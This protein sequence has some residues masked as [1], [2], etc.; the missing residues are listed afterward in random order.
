[1]QDLPLALRWYLWTVY[2]ACLAL[3]A[4]QI[5]PLIAG[6]PPSFGL[7]R[8]A[9]F[10]L[11][12][13]YIGERTYLQVGASLSQSLST[14]VHLTVVLLLPPPYPVVITFL[15]VLM[16]H[17]ANVHKPLYKRAFNICH[18]TL[19][20]GL[21]SALA[22]LVATPR[23]LLQSDHFLQA[24]PIVV[25]YYALDAGLLVA[26]FALLERRSPWLVWRQA[27]RPLL[28]PEVA[29][30][31]T[32]V[33][34][35]V[36]WL[37]HPELLVLF[38]MPVVALRAA[39]RAISQAEAQAAALQRRSEQLEAVL[40]AGQRLRLQQDVAA[41]L[42]SAAAAAQTIVG[43]GAVAGYA[44]SEEE[45]N[46][47][48]RVALVP[49][50]SPIDAP[51]S[52]PR[53]VLGDIVDGLEG[54]QTVLL[55]LE[56]EGEGIVGVLRLM[57]VPTALSQGDRNAL[58]ILATETSIA[59]ENAR[60]FR[61][62]QEARHAAEEAVRVRDDFLAAASHDL[63]TPLTV[64]SGLVQVILARLASGRALDADQ[65]QAQIATVNEAT[66]RMRTTVEEI[67]DA[68]QLQMGQTL[69][70]HVT[71]LDLGELVRSVA[72]RAHV[73][74]QQATGVCVSVQASSGIDIQ[75]DHARL[76]RVVENII[77]NAVKY[78]P[79]GTPVYV[80]VRAVDTWGTLVV[81]DSGVGIPVKELPH[82]FTHF[83]RASTSI[84]I[85]GTGIG[86]AGSKTIVEQHGGHISVESEVDRGTTV[87]VFLP[88]QNASLRLRNGSGSVGHVTTM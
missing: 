35:A 68:A 84:G 51:A 81:R 57:D 4:G 78:S 12:L 10:F 61:Q 80:E 16:T 28:L 15:A 31:T 43:A 19:A 40:A 46:L 41:L 14:T 25:V 42:R 18:S 82:I 45:P 26:V 76:E 44:P 59:L 83:Y 48:R 85:P 36:V 60:L 47:L 69:A 54:E 66:T 30:C 1:M 79:Q 65:L 5:T 56:R 23:T 21:S 22:T 29:A 58:A 72:Q 32:G 75:G 74:N 77:A 39:F 52:L 13:T 9:A 53:P 86:L 64:I 6:P 7:V 71:A 24:L 55:P 62:T 33:L 87:T 2:A 20:V 50:A 88:L 38:V 67:T 63:R 73:S 3:V 17:A 70:M 37:Y 8:E 11:L 27:Y 34:A 49:A